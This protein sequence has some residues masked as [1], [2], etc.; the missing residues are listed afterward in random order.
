MHHF[1]VWHLQW[2][3]NQSH[4]NK[5]CFRLHKDYPWHHTVLLLSCCFYH[6]FNSKKTQN[7]TKPQKKKPSKTPQINKPAEGSAF[8]SAWNGLRWCQNC[9]GPLGGT[10]MLWRCTVIL[11]ELPGPG[12]GLLWQR[13]GSAG[14]SY[15]Q[16][17]LPSDP[18]AAVQERKSAAVTQTAAF[19]SCKGWQR[20]PN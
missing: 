9:R 20:V 13:V 12:W 10:T 6:F 5:S 16:G 14:D 8:H 19:C 11:A 3:C 17:I 2:L 1:P 18:G 7:P 4:T 15:P